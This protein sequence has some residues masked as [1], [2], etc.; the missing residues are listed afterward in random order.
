[1]NE[2]GVVDY[3]DFL[4]FITG[5]CDDATRE[6]KRVA[7][8]AEE[9]HTW[10]VDVQNKK[11]AKEG[12]IDSSAAWKLLK[13]KDGAIPHAHVD[14]ILRARQ[15][16]VTPRELGKLAV[17]IAPQTNGRIDQKS[18]HRFINHKPKKM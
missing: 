16:R 17:V 7:D 1:M 18:L 14:K 13:S 11:V 5:V 12:N 8:A 6:A 3:V 2:D 15:I 4:R 10:C 9:F